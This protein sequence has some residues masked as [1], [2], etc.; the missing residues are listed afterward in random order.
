M[1]HIHHAF[2]TGSS[3]HS[4]AH[5]LPSDKQRAVS[6]P[7]FPVQDPLGQPLALVQVP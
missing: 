6:D 1:L 4:Q 3:N 5:S 7:L 2:C